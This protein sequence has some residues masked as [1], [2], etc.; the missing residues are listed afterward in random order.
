MSEHAGFIERLSDIPSIALQVREHVPAGA[1]CY[2]Y[3]DNTGDV[4]FDLTVQAA[5]AGM[6]ACRMDGPWTASELAQA[7]LAQVK[8]RRV[9]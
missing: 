3:V 4:S 6:P 9:A 5:H 7:L 2:V 8:S 1:S